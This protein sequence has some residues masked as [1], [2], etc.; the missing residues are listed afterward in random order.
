VDVFGSPMAVYQV[1]NTF[2]S[3]YSYDVSTRFTTRTAVTC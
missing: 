3:V 2:I 1:G